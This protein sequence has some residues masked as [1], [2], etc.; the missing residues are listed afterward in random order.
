MFDEESQNSAAT[1]ESSATFLK[2]NEYLH[3]TL[4]TEEDDDAATVITHMVQDEPNEAEDDQNKEPEENVVPSITTHSFSDD[5]SV[6]LIYNGLQTVDNGILKP[7]S[8]RSNGSKSTTSRSTSKSTNRATM[9]KIKKSKGGS[10]GKEVSL[11]IVLERLCKQE[12]E[13]ALPPKA[14]WESKVKYLAGQIDYERDNGMKLADIEAMLERKKVRA[15]Q[16]TEQ[17][18]WKSR[19]RDLESLLEEKKKVKDEKLRK[20]ALILNDLK[21]EKKEMKK[22]EKPGCGGGR[23]SSKSNTADYMESNPNRPSGPDRSA[24]LVRTVEPRKPAGS[25]SRKSKNSS[26]RSSAPKK[27]A[28]A[29][30]GMPPLLPPPP[31]NHKLYIGR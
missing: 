3:A 13:V 31:A 18:K 19:V 16:D 24:S 30:P 27:S 8:T 6:D 29:I 20:L 22:Y 21:K 23:W 1:G 5:G 14:A 10:S 15:K 28:A 7:M 26:T 11:D 25:S 12:P 9:T 2:L 17:A 4:P